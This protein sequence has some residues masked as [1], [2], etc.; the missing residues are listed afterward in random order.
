MKLA[1]SLIAVKP[2][3]PTALAAKSMGSLWPLITPWG[4][5]MSPK[6]FLMQSIRYSCRSSVM[7]LKFLHA[8]ITTSWE[9]FSSHSEI[10][11]RAFW[12]GVEETGLLVRD[13]GAWVGTSPST[14]T[15][16]TGWGVLTQ[17]DIKHGTCSQGT[18]SLLNGS[19]ELWHCSCVCVC[20]CVCTRSC[21][22]RC[23]CRCS[24]VQGLCVHGYACVCVCAQKQRAVLIILCEICTPGSMRGQQGTCTLRPRTEPP[25]PKGHEVLWW[26]HRGPRPE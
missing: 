21:R 13:R 25:D 10:S 2:S 11:M 3:A 1:N 20:L 17:K 12:V 26:G 22:Y 6:M 24:C 19:G 9:W 8:R 23:T 7:P 4:H 16:Q 18:E 14:A 5:S 15:L